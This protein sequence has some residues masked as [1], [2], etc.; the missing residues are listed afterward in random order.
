MKKEF[1]FLMIS[2][3][4]ENGGNA[5]LRFFD[6][7]PQMYVYPFESQIGT[8]LVKDLLSSMFPLKYRWPVFPLE[9]TPE[10]D[11]KLVIDEE[12]KV[13]S[14]T[15]HVSKFRNVKFIFSDNE[16][17]NFYSSYI[18]QM[19]RTRAN[20]IASFFIATFDA[21]KNYRRSEREI[22]YVGYSPTIIIDA[23]KIL[24][25]FPNAHILHIV[26]NPWSAYADTK[27]RPIPL[28]LRDYM[29][30]WIVNQYYALL[31]Q[32]KFSAQVH[33]LRI[34]DIMENPSKILGD[35]C[36]KIGLETSQS[37][38]KPTWNG[39]LL[40]TIYPWGTLKEATPEYNKLV[41]KNLTDQERLEIHYYAWQYLTV[42]DYKDFLLRC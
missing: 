2:A 10:E 23:D 5:T 36:Q 39:E 31:Y 42:F 21:W 32:K 4:Y 14:Q 9:G 3:M 7:H 18:L 29:L 27:K 25:D 40:D 6:G 35:I 37:L 24:G 33:I 1:S 12:C 28:S 34:E 38:A 26:R 30:G 19:G 16:R 13:R 41:T 8:P 17:F 22:F 15:P 20:N 11:Y